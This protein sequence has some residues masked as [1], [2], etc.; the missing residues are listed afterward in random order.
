MKKQNTVQFL[1]IEIKFRTS[2]DIPKL[3]GCINLGGITLEVEDREYMLDVLT[4]NFE[5]DECGGT[6]ISCNLDN[7]EGT[8]EVF[9]DCKFN[10]TD[11]DFSNRKFDKA[12][13]F[14]EFEDSADEDYAS[15]LDSI[16]LFYRLGDCTLALELTPE[17]FDIIN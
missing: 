4:S 17:T 5:N 2:H 14:I 11:A 9:E 6:T 13:M 12:E 1:S 7:F 8:L 10:V 16:T 3:M 15:D